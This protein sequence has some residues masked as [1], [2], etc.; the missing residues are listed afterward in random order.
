MYST[1]I[2]DCVV[3]VALGKVLACYEN[4]EICEELMK[5]FHDLEWKKKITDTKGCLYGKQ[6]FPWPMA[7]RD[8]LFH[9]TG[10]LDIKNKAFI[11]VSRSIAPGEKYYDYEAQPP[12]SDLVRLHV[13]AGYN[14]FQYL[15]PNK[16]RHIAIWNTD[17]QIG[18]VPTAVL[19]YFMTNTLYS[20]MTNLQHFSKK[21]DDPENNQDIYKYYEAKKPW[22]D[23]GVELLLDYEN[24]KHLPKMRIRDCPGHVSHKDHPQHDP[25]HPNNWEVFDEE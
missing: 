4:I 9:A 24:R 1:T 19:D 16:T 3:D 7:T 18:Y 8:M 23:F 21:L 20:L 11:S 12:T 14:F 25:N 5:D 15:G 2:T 6:Y 17:P 22:Y 10:V 13:N